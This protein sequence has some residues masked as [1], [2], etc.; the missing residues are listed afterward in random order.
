MNEVYRQDEKDM[1]TI[2]LYAL[3]GI[4]LIQPGDDV[5]SIICDTA[6]KQ[7]FLFQDRDIVVIA[8]KIISKAEG[9][10]IDTDQIKPSK[11]AQLLSEKV[12][13]DP[14][15]LEVILR[16]TKKLLIARPNLLL[17]ENL[18]GIIGTKSGVDSS[19]TTEGPKGK[20]VVAILPKDPDLSAAK[21]RKTIKEST[22][23][24]VAVVINDTFG[25]SDRKGSIGMAIGFSGIS[26]IYSPDIKE[27]IH[28]K[29]RNPQIAQVDEI[30]AS[31]S[32]LMGQ[33]NERRPVIILRGLEYKTSET[34]GIKDL[35]YPSTKYIQ[36]ALDV[37]RQFEK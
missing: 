34:D 27:D 24:E 17:T 28:G 22:G 9:Q 20:K 29:V 18:L 2:S 26:A 19:N 7:N 36:D 13:I 31:A 35:L 1:K 37:S 30:S 8:S 10:L 33:T 14:K 21:I 16:E 32:L 11:E 12:G 6:E 25:R 4:P 15:N 3:M 23:K 5:G